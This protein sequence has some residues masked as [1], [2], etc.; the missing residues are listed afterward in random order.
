MAQRRNGAPRH[1]R[2]GAMT[3][4]SS[5]IRSCYVLINFRADTKLEQTIRGI[6]SWS[7]LE[8]FP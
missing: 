4:N 8:R 7:D 2:E 6:Y 1:G 5:E 3:F